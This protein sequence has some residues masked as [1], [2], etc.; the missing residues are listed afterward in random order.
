LGTLVLI[1]IFA[2]PSVMLL[3]VTALSEVFA[4]ANR[5][6]GVAVYRLQVISEAC[7][8]LLTASGLRLLPD[9]LTRDPDEPADT[10]FVAGPLAIPEP[11]GSALQAWFRRQAA[12][13]RRVGAV[14]TGVF[15]L[16]ASG[17]LDGRRVTTHWRHADQLASQ[18]PAVIVQPGR[19][20]VRDGRLFT[21]AG[22][23]AGMDLALALVED[24]LGAAAATTVAR[25]LTM[26]VR[27]DGGQA[28]LSV[29]L[30]SQLATRPSIRE[31]VAWIR[32]DPSRD[33]S[34]AELRRRAA[35]S[36]RN[37]ARVFR[38]ETGMTPAEFVET[39]RVDAAQR[40]LRE[41]A[42]PLKSIAVECGFGSTDALRRAFVRR[43]GLTPA[44]YRSRW[45][46]YPPAP[47]C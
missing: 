40:L 8:P 37:F 39:T 14:R 7:T 22:A 19:I 23:A 17:L 41:T 35:M 29:Q 6:A 28:Q 42:L 25:L 45:S 27:R 15:L 33:L 10:L 30:A 9:R 47:D 21:A 3:D 34:I 36:E 4:E 44:S 32:A 24:D 38:Q 31:V 16:A 18:F 2:P 43:Q 20:F 5:V 1:S 46:G 13:A 26:A 12:A 11:S